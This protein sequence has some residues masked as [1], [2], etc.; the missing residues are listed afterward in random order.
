MSLDSWGRI[1][2]LS[3]SGIY[4]IADGVV[5]EFT[6]LN[7]DYVPS[8]LYNWEFSTVDGVGGGVF[9]SS[10]EGLWSVTQSTAAGTSGSGVSFYPQP[11]VSGEDQLR[12]CGPDESSQVKVEFFSID[13]SY[14]GALEA[15]SVSDWTWDGTLDGEAVAGGV[16][17]VLVTVDDTVYRTRISVV[18]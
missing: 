3:E 18:R 9:F 12:F 6:D 5:D 8:N 13:G 11:F 7:S 2:C 14:L 16:Y 15:Q 4:R 1:W 10:A 17:P